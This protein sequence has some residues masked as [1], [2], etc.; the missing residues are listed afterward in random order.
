MKVLYEYHLQTNLNW[1]CYKRE[2]FENTPDNIRIIIGKYSNQISVSELN[3]IRSD[4]HYYSLHRLSEAE[5]K[6]IHLIYLRLKS[7]A[8][9][10]SLK[11]LH[12]EMNARRSIIETHEDN[13]LMEI[14]KLKE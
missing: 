9:E 8:I 3:K 13:V 14:N 6:A 10:C 12:D 2:V 7:K 1:T 11:E 5:E 4:Y